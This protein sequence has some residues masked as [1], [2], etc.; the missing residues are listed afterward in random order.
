MLFKQFTVGGLDQITYEPLRLDS[1]LNKYLSTHTQLH[2]VEVVPLG[3]IP[4]S[5]HGYETV[6]VLVIFDT[7]P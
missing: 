7:N 6:E 3:R 4:G 5:K 1:Q 2:V